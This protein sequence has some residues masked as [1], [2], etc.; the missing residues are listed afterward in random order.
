MRT[1]AATHH[2]AQAHPNKF[3]QNQGRVDLKLF[4]HIATLKAFV[5]PHRQ[6][7]VAKDIANTMLMRVAF[8]L[9]AIQLPFKFAPGVGGV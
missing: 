8:L 1:S 9:Q 5:H 3:C 6:Q 2:L 4:V 7:D